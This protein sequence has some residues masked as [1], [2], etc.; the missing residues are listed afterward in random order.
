MNRTIKFRGKGLLDEK[1][2]HGVGY[3]DGIIF[4]PVGRETLRFR[5]DRDSVA[6]LIAVDKNTHEVYE[7]DDIVCPDGKSPCTHNATFDDYQSILDG[8]AWLI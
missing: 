2:I 8:K 5:V 6:Q 7:G 4:S 1:Y 3:A